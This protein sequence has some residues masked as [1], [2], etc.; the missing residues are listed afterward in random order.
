MTETSVSSVVSSGL[1]CFSLTDAA[2]RMIEQ[3]AT[4]GIGI[5]FDAKGG[6][7]ITQMHVGF[8][9]ED[10]ERW[11]AGYDASIEQRK[12]AGE[13]SF[14][15]YRNA[16]D[17]NIV[18]VVSEQES[19]ERLLEFFN[20]PDLQEKMKAAGIVEMGANLLVEEMDRGVH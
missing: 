20:S 1:C 16:D 17:P 8:R 5:W 3:P 18:T 2:V 19:A 6:T 14:A 11:K 7:M 12:A 13:I 9:V 15:V 10:Y 4:A